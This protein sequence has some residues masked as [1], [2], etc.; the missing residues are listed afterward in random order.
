MSFFQPR[1]SPSTSYSTTSH[2]PTPPKR[3]SPSARRPPSSS[4]HTPK[5]SPSFPSNSPAPVTSTP[6]EPHKPAKR[7]RLSKSS[8]FNDG[9]RPSGGFPTNPPPPPVEI[10]DDDDYFFGT[11]NVDEI[12]C[13]PFFSLFSPISDSFFGRSL[14]TI[15]PQL[16]MENP[17][18][19]HHQPR[20]PPHLL[21][22]T[23]LFLLLPYLSPL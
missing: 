10:D 6:L 7:L 17:R 14:S 16:P 5:P 20:G 19:I 1:S 2:T 13:I 3:P 8:S 23:L 11:I 22:H 12:V 21:P 9:R 15:N 18:H 4:F